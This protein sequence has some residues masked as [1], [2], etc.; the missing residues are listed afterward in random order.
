MREQSIQLGGS[1]FLIYAKNTAID[2]QDPSQF[3][4]FEFF[5]YGIIF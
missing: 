5:G 2:N 4:R 3:C 1:T